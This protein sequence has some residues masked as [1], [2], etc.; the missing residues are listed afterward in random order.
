MSAPASSCSATSTDAL[1]AYQSQILQENFVRFIE[2]KDF[3]TDPL[4][5]RFRGQVISLLHVL[6]QPLDTT[7]TISPERIA[8]MQQNRETLIS[9]EGGFR[10]AAWIE[11]AFELSA[12]AQRLKRVQKIEWLDLFSPLWAFSDMKNTFSYR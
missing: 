11:K 4:L 6:D 3:L 9:Q 2:Y 1:H 7:V 12:I 5:D 10:N 8:A